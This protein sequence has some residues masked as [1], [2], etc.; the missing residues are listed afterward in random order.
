M[1]LPLIGIERD[2]MPVMVLRLGRHPFLVE[3]QSEPGMCFG[4]IRQKLYQLPETRLRPA[5]RRGLAN[6]LVKE[7]KTAGNDNLQVSK[8]EK[9]HDTTDRPLSGWNPGGWD[10][11]FCAAGGL[12]ENRHRVQ[13]ATRHR[14]NGACVAAVVKILF[15]CKMPLDKEMRFDVWKT[16]SAGILGA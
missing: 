10:R 4:K 9:K 3:Q 16:L 13:I 11:H 5:G 7:G 14:D 2:G 8:G 12:R 6:S 15:K 1:Y